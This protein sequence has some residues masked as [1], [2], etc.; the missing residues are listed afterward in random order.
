LGTSLPGPPGQSPV[1]PPLVSLADIFSPYLF[2][3]D[4][5]RPWN[6][7]FSVRYPVLVSGVPY[8]FLPELHTSTQ[9]PLFLVFSSRGG[10]PVEH[11]EFWRS[12]PLAPPPVLCVQCLG[13]CSSPPLYP[14][15][16]LTPAPDCFPPT[17]RHPPTAGGGWAVSV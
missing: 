15:L 14:L 17:L 5:S 4:D 2:V 13:V 6:L 8:I 10:N 9:V 11:L 1:I 16:A 3:G 12:H 7:F